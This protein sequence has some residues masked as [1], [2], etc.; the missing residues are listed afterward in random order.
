MAK[1]KLKHPNESFE[2]LLRRFKKA[3][4]KDDI[5]K[6]VRKN[7]FFEKPSEKRKRAK[8]AAIKRAQKQRASE[9]LPSRKPR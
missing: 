6:D 1:A 8:A 2:S 7:E 4:D 5:I 9:A 3:V